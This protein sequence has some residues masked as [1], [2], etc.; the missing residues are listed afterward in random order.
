[1]A[2]GVQFRFNGG[3]LEQYDQVMQRM[4]LVGPDAPALD[5]LVFHWVAATQGG[6]QVSDVWESKDQ[7]D[8]FAEE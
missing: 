5:G 2:V 1:M 4:G 6:I 8:R 3:T 7:F